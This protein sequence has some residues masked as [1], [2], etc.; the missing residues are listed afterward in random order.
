MARIYTFP[1]RTE[2]PAELWVVSR[3]R[4]EIDP[5]R[6]PTIISLAQTVSA[7]F[8]ELLRL[9]EINTVRQKRLGL[10]YPNIDILDLCE[11]LGQMTGDHFEACVF[12]VLSDLSDDAAIGDEG[13]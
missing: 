10:M 4:G 12:E 3:T 2:K 8:G 9:A 5:D 13:A 11:V 6:L 1:S 7:A